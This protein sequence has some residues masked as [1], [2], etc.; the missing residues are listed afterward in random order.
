MP[1][2]LDYSIIPSALSARSL[3][4]DPTASVLQNATKRYNSTENTEG[5]PAG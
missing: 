5:K 3:N 4:P 2:K 1:A